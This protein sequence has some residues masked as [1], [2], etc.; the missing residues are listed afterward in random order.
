MRGDPGIGGRDVVRPLPLRHG[1]GTEARL[2]E[3]V[4]GHPAGA[5]GARRQSPPEPAP[6]C[7]HALFAVTFLL[8]FLLRS[9]EQHRCD[10]RSLICTGGG[11]IDNYTGIGNMLTGSWPVVSPTGS[12]TGWT[13]SGKDQLNS[14]PSSITVFAI[15][16]QVPSQDQ[17]ALSPVLSRQVSPSGSYPAMTANMIP[18]DILVGGGAVDTY[19]GAGNLLTAS[20]P[21]LQGNSGWTAA[22]KDQGAIDQSG[23]IT[24]VAG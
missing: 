2:L 20:Y 23:T 21:T 17:G 8:A 6:P 7:F 5:A 19:T 12:V 4:C 1:R 22:G 10:R 13:A 18:G 3:D 16:I 15:G 14:D 24:V 9:G 11:A